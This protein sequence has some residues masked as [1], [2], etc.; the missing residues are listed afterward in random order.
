M[1]DKEHDGTMKLVCLTI[2]LNI[3]QPNLNYYSV[4]VYTHILFVFGLPGFVIT[5]TIKQP[6]NGTYNN[7]R[8]FQHSVALIVEQTNVAEHL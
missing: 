6:L 5:E 4:L 8:A 7:G 2:Q 3:L 1:S